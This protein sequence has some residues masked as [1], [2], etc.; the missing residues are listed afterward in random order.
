MSIGDV[1]VAYERLLQ[2][3]DSAAWPPP[4]GE[5][6]GEEGNSRFVIFDGRH[7]YIAS[8]MLGRELIL[9]AWLAEK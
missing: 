2:L 3:G 5:W 7:E 6:E 9:V 4:N 1:K 8:Q